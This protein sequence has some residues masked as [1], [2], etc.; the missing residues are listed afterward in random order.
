MN[1]YP[2]EF[3]KYFVLMIQNI[4]KSIYYRGFEIS[5]LELEKFT[6]VSIFAI[7]S[8]ELQINIDFE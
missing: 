4:Q 6:E 3:Q 1:S 2:V 8:V 7:E 5:T